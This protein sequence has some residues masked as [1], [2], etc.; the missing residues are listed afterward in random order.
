MTP[1]KRCTEAPEETSYT[2]TEVHILDRPEFLAMRSVSGGVMYLT[3]NRALC[4]QYYE[5][6]KPESHVPKP[7]EDVKP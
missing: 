6:F 1:I 3:H 4:A 5:T 7:S 2:W